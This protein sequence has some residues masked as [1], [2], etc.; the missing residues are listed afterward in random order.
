MRNDIYRPRWFDDVNH[1]RHRFRGFIGEP[2]GHR[3]ALANS[4]ILDR[5]P[6]TR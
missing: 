4:G 3:N 1:I 2:R 5:V 6:I